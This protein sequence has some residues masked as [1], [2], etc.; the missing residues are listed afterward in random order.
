MIKIRHGKFS[1]VCIHILIIMLAFFIQTS[2][3]PLIPFF[4]S[5]PN[6]LLIITFSYGLLYGDYIGLIT[7]IFCGLLCDMYY[8]GVFGSF[9]L[10]YSLIGFLN[11]MLSTSF[12]E[13][14]ITTPMILSLVNGFAYN[15][16][17]YFVHFL[18]RR[19]FNVSYYFVRIMIPSVL[20]TLI[21]TVIVYKL[22][23]KFH[24]VWKS[25]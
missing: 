25:K 23:Y 13:N 22:I 21:I 1:T 2:I 24:F 10:I 15:L 7:G 4:T 14:S 11:G 5:S 19:K 16:Y 17:I 9:I 8:D 18:I 6:L 20:F 3:F 12:F